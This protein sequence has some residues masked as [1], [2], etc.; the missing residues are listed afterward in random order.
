MT[1]EPRKRR[2]KKKKSSRPKPAAAD[3]VGDRSA[4]VAERA[5][6]LERWFAPITG[7]PA[8]TDPRRARL[9]QDGLAQAAGMD[10]LLENMRSSW[11][12]VDVAS[13]RVGCSLTVHDL[14]RLC[15]RSARWADWAAAQPPL[16][17]RPPPRRRRKAAAP[18]AA[19]PDAAA[20]DAAAPDAAAGAKP[21]RKKKRRPVA[22][23]TT[24]GAEPAREA[25]KRLSGDE[26]VHFLQSMPAD[27]LALAEG[28]DTKG[29]PCVFLVRMRDRAHPCCC[30]WQHARASPVPSRRRLPT[31][32]TSRRPI[33]PQP[34]TMSRFRDHHPAT[35]PR[36]QAAAVRTRRLCPSHLP[37]PS[38]TT[39][40]SQS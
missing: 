18:D 21:K 29:C 33:C 14:F 31:P 12:D 10:V 5:L 8:P 16:T 9:C 11:P 19:A 27:V 34:P 39:T 6:W 35:L 4:R 28:D 32:P 36:R 2:V 3:D 30:C 37:T 24:T 26:F 15:R 38:S 7:A 25:Q 17:T 13:V 22:A 1:E 23:A 40:K 20:P